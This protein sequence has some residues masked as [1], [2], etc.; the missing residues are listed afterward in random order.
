MSDSTSSTTHPPNASDEL[1]H[2]QCAMLLEGASA[3]GLLAAP[4]VALQT[5]LQ[6]FGAIGEQVGETS[7][8]ISTV[9]AMAKES[10]GAES[11]AAPNHPL[12][13]LVFVHQVASLGPIAHPSAPPSQID[14][15]VHLILRGDGAS[16][17]QT[18]AWV[19]PAHEHGMAAER[20]R[21][22]GTRALPLSRAML[23]PAE[24]G[25]ASTDLSVLV[26]QTWQTAL[27]DPGSTLHQVIAALASAASEAF[28]KP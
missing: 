22:L 14:L 1:T 6:R 2:V 12:R 26:E 25:L 17:F 20:L 4:R 28:P 7:M 24:P 23:A 19:R 11:R 8:R 21:D 16:W 3:G 9:G 10:P 15:Q 5:A 27:N 18:V 13:P